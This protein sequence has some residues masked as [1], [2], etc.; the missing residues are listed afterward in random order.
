MIPLRGRHQ[1]SIYPDKGDEWQER[2]KF[3]ILFYFIFSMHQVIFQFSGAHEVT[4]KAFVTERIKWSACNGMA[5]ENVLQSVLNV[6]VRW[7]VMFT[8]VSLFGTK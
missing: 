8:G 7:N 4:K 1:S 6:H 3:V 5:K 2:T